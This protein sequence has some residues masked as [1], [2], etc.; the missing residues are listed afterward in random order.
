MYFPISKK[1]K[2]EKGKHEIKI[3]AEYFLSAYEEDIRVTTEQQ[4]LVV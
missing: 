2:K 1:Y 3:K 4:H